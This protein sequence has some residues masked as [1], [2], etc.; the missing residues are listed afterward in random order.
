MLEQLKAARRV[1]VPLVAIVSPDPAASIAT[2]AKGFDDKIPILKWDICAGLT[3]VNKPG[4]AA[5]GGILGDQD[6]SV[7][8]NPT[9]MLGMVLRKMPKDGML[10]ML[11]GQRFANTQSSEGFGVIQ[12][13]WNCRDP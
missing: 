12:G 13:L 5:V 4:A 11:N 6:A 9:E 2:V 10:F 8:T 3:A 7:T 1:S